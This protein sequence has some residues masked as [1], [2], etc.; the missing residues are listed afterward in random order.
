MNDLVLIILSVFSL[1]VSFFFIRLMFWLLAKDMF[2]KYFII[3]SLI[4]SLLLWLSWF[5]TGTGILQK[6]W[7]YLISDNNG[8]FL[9]V[10]II[11]PLIYNTLK[12]YYIVEKHPKLKNEYYPAVELVVYMFWT[13]GW[14]FLFA[15]LRLAIW[16][17]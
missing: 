1:F 5:I 13:I 14:Y 10:I 17:N 7:E 12:W 16:I 8:S 2:Y 11:I 9:L 4:F 3:D 6:E 15:L